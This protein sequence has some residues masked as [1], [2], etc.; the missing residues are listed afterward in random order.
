MN[1]QQ[2]WYKK[3][4]ITAM[5]LTIG[6]S[7][8]LVITP[9]SASAATSSSTLAN[10]VVS[11]GDNFL[12]RPYVFGAKSGQTRT[13]DCSSFTQYVYKNY[14]INLPRTSKAQSKSGSYVPRSQLRKGDLIFFS[15]P[16]KPGIV[17][18]VAI[19]A[20]NGTILHTYGEGGVRFTKLSSGTWSKRYMT[21]R[22]VL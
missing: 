15:N 21:A 22:R 4:V 19:Y 10:R 3:L 16:G 11:F 8:S 9:H 17:N 12:G 7:S 20:G 1:Y 14:G 2:K 18:H 5:A 13:F 6:L